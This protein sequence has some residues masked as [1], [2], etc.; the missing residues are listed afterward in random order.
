[1]ADIIKLPPAGD[2]W[3]FTIEVYRRSDG[4]P[5]ARLIDARTSLIEAGDMQPHEKLHEIADML[6]KSVG[7]L[8]ADAE[9]L[10][11]KSTA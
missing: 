4:M 1:M 2:V 8:R 9:A 5:A 6:E 11:P 3:Q 7:P 10:K